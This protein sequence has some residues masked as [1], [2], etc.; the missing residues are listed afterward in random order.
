MVHIYVTDIGPFM[1]PEVFEKGLARVSGE[2]REKVLVYRREKDRARSLAAGLL[3]KY[4][5]QK[6]GH[7]G[8][9]K[10]AAGSGGKPYCCNDEGFYFNLSH[11]GEFAACAVSDGEV[12]I[13]IQF[14][15]PGL[16]FGIAERFF[17]GEENMLLKGAAGED[18][19]EVLF[20]KLWAMKESY[21]K[22]TGRGLHQELSSV[23]CSVEQGSVREKGGAGVPVRLYDGLAGYEVAV[24]PGGEAAE[25]LRLLKAPELLG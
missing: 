20:Y 16:S 13:D 24:C 25:T 18:E 4:A 9:P 22:Y 5:W 3:L 19:R 14:R 12:G 10:I 6:E 21:L 1:L 11:S 2:R 7:G 17:S 8:N 23:L 15:K